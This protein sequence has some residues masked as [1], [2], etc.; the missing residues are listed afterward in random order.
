MAQI[1]SSCKRQIFWA[2][3]TKGGKMP[4]DLKPVRNGNIDLVDGVVHVVKP[5]PTKDRHVS[6]FSTC[7]NGALHRKGER[8]T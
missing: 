8:K 6:H 3:T 5:D 4:L 7:P 1:C 2:K